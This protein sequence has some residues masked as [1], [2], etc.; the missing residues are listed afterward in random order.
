MHPYSGRWWL[1]LG[2]VVPLAVLTLSA[3]CARAQGGLERRDNVEYGQVDGERLLLDLTVPKAPATGLRPVMMVVHGGAWRSG[4]KSGGG[5]RGLA[6]AMAQRGYVVASVEYRFAPKWHWPA[7]IDDVQRAVR[8]MR[9]HAAEFGADPQR[10]G[11]IGGSAGGH[12]VSL[13]GTMATREEVDAELTGV[14]SQVQAVVDLFGPA[15]LTLDTYLAELP[16]PATRPLLTQLLTDF[17]G[18]PFAAAPARWRE[19]SPLSHV[20]ATSAPFYIIHGTADKLV[21]VNQSRR[22]AAALEKAGVEVKLDVLEGLGHGPEKAE[23]QAP[24]TQAITRAVEFLD[25]HLKR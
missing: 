4:S 5:E 18:Q 14:P 3:G 1:P 25:R 6:G 21:G 15:D 23:H 20:S 22:L 24:F 19:A 16:D 7:Q 12:L 9:Q 17:L 2:A 13:L 8:W 10:V 11:A